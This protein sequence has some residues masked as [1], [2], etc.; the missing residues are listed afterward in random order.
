MTSSPFVYRYE[1]FLDRPRWLYV[2]GRKE[3]AR[4]VLAQ[5]HSIDGDPHGTSPL[6]NLEMAEIEEHV[7][8]Q[9]ADSA[10]ELRQTQLI[11]DLA[12]YIREMVG[13]PP[14]VPHCSGSLSGIHGHFDW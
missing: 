13:L 3:E 14:V 1:S 4:K 2:K 6:I 9:G 8:L 11:P 5:L 10:F 7:S 12:L